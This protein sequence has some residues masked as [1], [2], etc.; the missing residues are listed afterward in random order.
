M[1]Y[2]LQVSQITPY[3]LK[4]MPQCVLCLTSLP[5]LVTLKDHLPSCPLNTQSCPHCKKGFQIK[6]LEEHIS[7]CSRHGRT[8]F[9]CGATVLANS[10]VEHAY[11]CSK[12]MPVRMYHGT[13][14]AAAQQILSSQNFQSSS[15]GLLGEGVYV[16]ADLTKALRY[17]Q[18][19]IE[20]AV[21]KGKS[22]TIAKRFHPQQKCWLRSG[23]DSAWIPPN[24]FVSTSRTADALGCA[25]DD[26]AALAGT[27]NASGGELEE[28]CIGDPRRV[29]P[30]RL[31]KKSFT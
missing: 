14:L 17:G 2:F 26:F 30:L 5:P 21:F 3:T 18:A 29:V 22:I 4:I 19:V 10:Y 7:S 9:N 23:Y 12:E 8:C 6:V 24:A 15:S 31:I 20:C 11:Q 1:L 25:D 16:T 28:H 27:R 13:S